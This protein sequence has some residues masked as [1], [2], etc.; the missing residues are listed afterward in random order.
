MP[1]GEYDRRLEILTAEAGRISAFARGARRP[2]SNLAA[3][4]RAFAFGQF[5]LFQGKSSYSLEKADISH[6]FNEL[7]RDVELTYYGFYFLEV[8][9]Y[10]SR[11]NIPASEELGLLYYSLRALSL[12]SL[13]NR[14]VR[15]VFE[16]KMLDINGLCPPPER[17]EAAEGRFAF[18]KDFQSGTMY[19][20]R[21]VIESPVKKLYTFRLSDSVL[22]EFAAAAAELMGMSTDRKFKSLEFLQNEQ[23][24]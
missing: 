1:I 22:K 4:A 11:E 15:A 21:F 7:T 13:D 16:I 12:D 24:E 20:I 5:E 19:A 10:F 17:L 8:S 9:R 18:A 23:Y 3:P 2:S 6:Y 14:L